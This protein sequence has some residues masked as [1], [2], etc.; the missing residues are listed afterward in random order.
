MSEKERILKIVWEV[1][2]EG[3]SID[4]VPDQDYVYEQIRNKVEN[5]Y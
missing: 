4:T 5:D 2:H 3:Y 1:L